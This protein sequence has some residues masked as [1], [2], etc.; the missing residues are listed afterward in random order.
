MSVGVGV[1]LLL[2]EWDDSSEPVFVIRGSCLARVHSIGT[3]VPGICID[4]VVSGF[5]SGKECHCHELGKKRW[6]MHQKLP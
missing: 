4:P 5:R 1:S 2:H 3:S 6:T